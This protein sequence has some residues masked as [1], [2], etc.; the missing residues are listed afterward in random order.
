MRYLGDR[1]D[2]PEMQARWR[3]AVARVFARIARQQRQRDDIEL[4][5]L[6]LGGEGA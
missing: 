1:Y 4:G 6:D 2:T 3:R 5:W